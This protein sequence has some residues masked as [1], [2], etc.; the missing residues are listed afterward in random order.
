M[1]PSARH[2]SIITT[3]T[4]LLIITL[5]ITTAT[6]VSSRSTRRSSSSSSSSS[7]SLLES[8][9]HLRAHADTSGSLRMP[10]NPDMSCVPLKSS[11]YVSSAC[12]NVD[13]N[14]YAWIQKQASDNRMLDWQLDA[15]FATTAGTRRCQRWYRDLMCRYVFPKCGTGAEVNGPCRSECEQFSLSCPGL[16]MSCAAFDTPQTGKC[17]TSKT[18]YAYGYS[19]AAAQTMTGS[20]ATIVMSGI[21]AIVLFYKLW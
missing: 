2:R 14:T 5:T 6:A 12:P 17:W 9:S 8:S 1:V 18:P 11:G 13:W 3:T 10:D 16:A 4:L 21:A 19:N 20:A 15:A 7:S